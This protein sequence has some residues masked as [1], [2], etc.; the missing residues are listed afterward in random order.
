MGSR[1]RKRLYP[2]SDRDLARIAELVHEGDFVLI[3]DNA[4]NAMGSARSKL[5]ELNGIIKFWLWRRG[6]PYV[7]VAP[8]T[9]KKFILGAGKGDKSFIIREVFKAYG[10]DAGTD[11][12]ADAC[13]LAHIGACL[14]GREEPRNKAQR[15][16]LTTLT[17]EKKKK[18][19]RLRNAV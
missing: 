18:R 2:V 14:V 11:D 13:V 5:A 1:I 12:E 3:E 10:L 7:L 15:D 17:A 19:R 9:L 8:T 6:I 16:V 4:F